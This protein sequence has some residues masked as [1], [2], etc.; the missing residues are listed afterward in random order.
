[1][2]HRI[3]TTMWHIIARDRDD[4]ELLDDGSRR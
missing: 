4:D 1:M 3:A 2:G